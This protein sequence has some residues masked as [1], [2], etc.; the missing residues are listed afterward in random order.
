MLSKWEYAEFFNGPIAE[1]EYKICPEGMAA[2]ALMKRPV[3]FFC[4]SFYRGVGVK[5]LL[6]DTPKG[7]KGVLYKHCH[8]KHPPIFIR[9]V[10]TKVFA[11]T[12]VAESDKVWSIKADEI[13]GNASTS[14]SGVYIDDITVRS[15]KDMIRKQLCV[16]GKTSANM[17]VEFIFKCSP[18]NKLKTVLKPSIIKKT[19]AKTLFVK[20]I[21]KKPAGK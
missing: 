14:F 3:A 10:S 7:M 5:Y 4:L 1:N 6:D 20:K 18:Q 16:E 19:I 12:A 2:A 11:L 9:P 8:N 13:G 21:M 15:M 17:I